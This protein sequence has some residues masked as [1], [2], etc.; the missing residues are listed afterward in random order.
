MISKQITPKILLDSDVIRHFLAGG[1]ILELPKIYPNQLVVL[2]IVKNELCRSRGIEKDIINFITFCKIELI[3]FPGDIEI[4]REYARL[5]RTFGN[6]ESACMAVAKYRRHYI[7]SSNLKDIKK[8]C[9]E[10]RITY[11]TTMDVLV[12]GISK[13]NLSE[14]E[15]DAFIATVKSKG[16]KLP[17]N[18]IKEYRKLKKS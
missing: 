17:T 2:D 3:P 13:G 12:D 15:C 8:Y 14:K 9:E 1:K 6:G 5:K 16:H 10:N 18:S 4:M 7:A 11:L